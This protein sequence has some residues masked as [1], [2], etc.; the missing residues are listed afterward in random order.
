LLAQGVIPSAQA[1]VERDT[2]NNTSAWYKLATY[3]TGVPVI[4]SLLAQGI[5]PT[6]QAL[7][8]RDTNDNAYAWYWLASRDKG[9]LVF[10]SLLAQ[11]IIPTAQALAERDTRNN[12]NAW[13]ML[14]AR[15]DTEFSV[16]QSLLA[17]GIIPTAQALSEPDIR[18]N[19]NAWYMLTTYEAG[20][21]VF[22]SLLSQ[23]IIPT[24]QALAE[25]DTTYNINAWHRLAIYETGFPVFQSL[26]A[27]GIIPNAQ[28]LAERDTTN[29]TNAWHRLAAYETGFPVL[30]SLLD[31]DILPAAHDCE[32]LKKSF[33]VTDNIIRRMN[34]VNELNTKYNICL[35]SKVAALLT[36]EDKENF[37]GFI[38]LF[39]LMTAKN[40]PK[41]YFPLE[42]WSLIGRYLLP[43][44]I[45]EI[46]FSELSQDDNRL[47]Y[48]KY[49]LIHSLDNYLDRP[50]A[51]FNSYKKRAASL[52]NEVLD[53]PDPRNTLFKQYFMSRNPKIRYVK[54]PLEEHQNSFGQ[55][56]SE[57]R[58]AKILSDGCFLN[59]LRFLRR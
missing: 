1:L 42:I 51:L 53:S 38:Y 54:R 27:Q 49:H 44:T 20:F 34:R 23:G 45:T 3:E 17:Q 35:Q 2:R 37:Y 25:R 21:P 58:F 32:Y 8:E 40:N 4:Q 14:A 10:Q 18:S 46:N 24:A 26:L 19:R 36:R 52:K 5:I 29:K 22:Q 13:F 47:T 15:G 30:Q 28:T 41:L 33:K 39:Y 55:K 43:P 56:V 9:I 12:T 6:A 31:S 48:I 11:G 57:Q 59:N 7:A 16:F 50:F